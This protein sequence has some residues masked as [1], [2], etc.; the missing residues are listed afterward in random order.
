[1]L[2]FAV[3]LHLFPGIPDMMK[4]VFALIEANYPEDLYASYVI[5]G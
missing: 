1:M 3:F 5:N 2:K 4:E